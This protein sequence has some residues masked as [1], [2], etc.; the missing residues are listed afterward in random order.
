MARQLPAVLCKGSSTNQMR[1]PAG[2][3]AGVQ[4]RRQ[5]MLFHDRIHA[6]RMLAEKLGKY[7][8][9]PDVMVLGLPRGGV[10]VAFAVAEALEAPLDVFLVRKL[11]LPGQEELAIGAIASGGVRV[12]N[13]DLV[14]TLR[15]PPEEIDA[16]AAEEPRGFGARERRHPA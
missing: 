9:R 7:A 14:D 4:G 10:P 2:G 8:H 6:G 13:E 12:L 15:M 1:A 16:I 5:V 3:S 11:G